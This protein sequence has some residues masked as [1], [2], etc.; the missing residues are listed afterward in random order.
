VLFPYFNSKPSKIPIS[1]GYNSQQKEESEKLA[2]NKKLQSLIG[3]LLF[4]AVNTRPDI[5]IAVSILSR[6]VKSPTQE[7]WIE[8]KRVVKYLLTTINMKLQLGNSEDQIVCFVDADFAGN[9]KDYKSTSGFIIKFGSGL[10]GWGCKKQNT[11]AL[12]STDA[13]CFAMVECCRELVW[14]LE[15][16]QCLQVKPLLPITLFEDNQS[17]MKLLITERVNHRSK[18]IGTRTNYIKDLIDMKLIQI[19]YCETE[20]MVADVLTKPLPA[21]KMEKFAKLMG[22]VQS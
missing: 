21:I 7:D 2:D 17:L 6:K 8:A 1:V 3:C 16:L 18:H 15:L 13:E 12:S 11:V 5:S 20:N 9:I 19:K 22:I 14:L 4:I 10:V